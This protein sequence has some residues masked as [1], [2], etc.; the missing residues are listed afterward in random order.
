MD[1]PAGES[2]TRISRTRKIAFPDQSSN[3]GVDLTALLETVLI[4]R[5]LT[6]DVEALISCSRKRKAVALNIDDSEDESSTPS[7]SCSFI[8]K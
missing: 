5:K 3:I 1:I 4:G 7:L 8:S 2:I 6:E